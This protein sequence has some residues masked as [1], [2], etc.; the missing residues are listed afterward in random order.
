MRLDE[1]RKERGNSRKEMLRVEIDLMMFYS[2]QFIDLIQFH[3]HPR[4]HFFFVFSSLQHLAFP[5]SSLNLWCECI[6]TLW[7]SSID[8]HLPFV[9]CWVELI[10]FPF[11]LVMTLT[12]MHFVWLSKWDQIDGNDSSERCLRCCESFEHH[13]GMGRNGMSIET[14]ERICRHYKSDR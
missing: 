3:I 13:R 1:G 2:C 12:F 10:S 4:I 6:V 5:S 14:G 9:V 8:F 7:N 11:A